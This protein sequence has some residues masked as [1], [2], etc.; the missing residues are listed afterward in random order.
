MKTV[1]GGKKKSAS[2]QHLPV[3]GLALLLTKNA[4]VR[5]QLTNLA[6]LSSRVCRFAFIECSAVLF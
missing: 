4:S 6:S 3:V 2:V 1:A 5:Y